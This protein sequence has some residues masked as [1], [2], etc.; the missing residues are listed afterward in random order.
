ML[1]QDSAEAYTNKDY[2]LARSIQQ[3]GW[4]NNQIGDGVVQRH[5]PIPTNP[6]RLQAF[7]Q[8]RFPNAKASNFRQPPTRYCSRRKNHDTRRSTSNIPPVLFAETQ[9]GRFQK[10]LDRCS[11]LEFVQRNQWSVN[12]QPMA[13][14]REAPFS[15]V[16]QQESSSRNAEIETANAKRCGTTAS[17]KK[18]M[19]IIYITSGTSKPM[20]RSRLAN[21]KPQC[22]N[23][24]TP[25][26]I[27]RSAKH[28]VW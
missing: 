23:Q 26:G 7:E 13:T 17:K 5:K 14:G 22:H 1:L 24:Q 11:A 15:E 19:K 8:N 12:R 10:H 2:F 3:K 18:A 4:R 16:C 6:D 28:L 9:A 20:P 21:R 27:S 25:L